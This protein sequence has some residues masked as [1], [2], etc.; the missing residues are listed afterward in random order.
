MNTA[1]TALVTGA[2]RG[3]GRALALHLASAG[4]RV[5]L[6]AHRSVEGMESAAAGIRAA[7]GSC[8]VVRADLTRE[9]GCLHAVDA[10]VRA[11]GGLD[12]L[13]NNS[14]VYH[15]KN[16]AELSA[17]EWFEEVNTT[18]TAVFLMTKAAL[19]HLRTSGA[20]RVVNIG[21]SSC[22]RPGARDLAVGYHVGKTGVYMLTRS[23]AQA[24]AR[25]G[26]TF[27]VVSPGWL[28]NSLDLPAADTIPAGR[29]GT[30][31]DIC[32]AV[33]F[34]LSPAAAYLNGSHLVAS[35]GWNLR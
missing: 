33:D 31:A 20:G 27:N 28:E 14:G 25:H 21:D 16:L 26:I 5:C 12:V 13:I 22:E 10:C 2:G 9:D 6:H 1:R 18:A 32:G 23:F 11:F 34:L 15:S 17:Q 24:E 3:L 19:P 35:G 8:A 7:G 30:F 4:F 29:H